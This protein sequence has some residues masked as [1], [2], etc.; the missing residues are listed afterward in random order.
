MNLRQT[1]TLS[2][3]QMQDSSTR[4][5]THNVFELV[6]FASNILRL[7]PG[8]L[9]SAGSPPGTNIERSQPRWMKAGDTVVCTIEG[10]GSLSNPVVADSR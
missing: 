8:D 7:Q 3:Q 4:Q 2:G 9:I 5:M 1:L 6:H 10:I